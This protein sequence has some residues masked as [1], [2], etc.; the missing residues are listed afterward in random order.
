MVNSGLRRCLRARRWPSPRASLVRTTC[1]SLTLAAGFAVAAWAPAAAQ[2]AAADPPEPA[3][4]Q[5]GNAADLS[6]SRTK[7]PREAE[8]SLQAMIGQML[9]IGFPGQSASEEWPR[10]TVRMIQD[11]RLGGIV[12]FAG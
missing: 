5:A 11:G 10:R 12:L 1:I 6:A 9:L 3:A 2:D 8:A 4:R 7:P